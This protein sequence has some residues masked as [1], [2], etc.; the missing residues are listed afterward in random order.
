VE[1]TFEQ[2]DGKQ[3]TK[4]LNFEFFRVLYRG[5]IEQ[6]LVSVRD[7][8]ARVL[9]EKELES[10]KEQGEQQV[11]MLVSFLK[12]DPKVLKSFLLESRESL[13]D[14]NAILKDPLTSKQDLK[15]KLDKMFISVHRMKGEASSM[16]FDAFR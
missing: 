9:L 6:V 8:T 16:N 5:E 1:T 3:V 15:D 2:K 11:E 4:Y 12:A 7:I 13:S 14:V 10:T